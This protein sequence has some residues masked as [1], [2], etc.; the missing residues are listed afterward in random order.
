MAS[1]VGEQ[2]TAVGVQ[3]LKS[4]QAA[5][6]T[7][8][9]YQ[10]LHLNTTGNQ[11]TALGHSALRSNTEGEYNIG[12]GHSALYANTTGDNNSA[13]GYAPLWKNTTGSN[14]TA[15][16]YF[17][18]KENTSGIG[19]IA[20]GYLTL[21]SNIT[22]SYNTALGTSADVS[23]SS[24]TNTTAIGYGAIVAA[25]NTMQLGNTSVTNV[26]TSG[27]ITAGA[28]TI[29]NTDG[30]SGQVLKTDGSGALSWVTQDGTG[31][32]DQNI[33]GSEL[34]GTTLTIGIEGGSSETVDLSGLQDG[35]GTDDQNISGSGLSGTTLTI[36]IEGGSNETVD[37][38]SLSNASSVNDLSDALIEDSSL[39]LG[40]DPSSST[41]TAQ[42]NIAVGATALNAVTTGDSNAA[43]GY[44]A[45][46]ANTTGW[47]NTAVG[48]DSLTTNIVGRNNTAVGYNASK[49][50][51]EHANS[52]FGAYALEDSTSGVGNT[53]VGY[54]ALK[55]NTTGGNNVALGSAA[56]DT[57]TTGTNNTV[58][59]AAADVASAALTNATA[60]GYEASVAASNTVQL[61]NTSVTNV[62]TS[63]SITAGAITIPNTDGS[64]NQVLKTDGSGTLSWV[65]KDNSN[66][67]WAINFIHSSEYENLATRGT[68]YYQIY[69]A[70]NMTVSKLTVKGYNSTN[71]DS[72]DSTIIGGIYRGELGSNSTAGGTLIGQGSRTSVN[73]LNEIA[74]SAE[75][76]QNLNVTELEPLIIALHVVTTADGND[77][78]AYFSPEVYCPTGLTGL[79]V[80]RSKNENL[81][82]L[83]SSPSA[84]SQ[85]N[86]CKGFVAYI[87]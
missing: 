59:G 31:T 44:G 82:S 39:Y 52:A 56:L 36:G 48:Y 37:L 57:N 63:G 10:A 2:N 11:N 6:S 60:I 41:S 22:G 5:Y 87:H 70:K 61:G 1:S 24:L 33:S 7:A 40:N 78:K 15:N 43:I 86:N 83:P 50:S 74:L 35:T 32:D 81:T 30:T 42:Y 72:N 80:A 77:Q 51:N 46:T 16:G 21:D 75:S 28:I 23:A 67:F 62:K 34:S 58:I 19:N 54:E 49:T 65:A 79:T 45:L 55:E 13:S 84:T 53:A 14:N 26:K 29:P 27:S 20:M 66:G 76:G 73:G 12:L 8:V 71:G 38:S 4:S 17:A 9:G 3:A 25:S 64:A 69:A 47:G 18:L 68:R 85:W